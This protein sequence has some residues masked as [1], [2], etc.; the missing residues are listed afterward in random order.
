MKRERQIEVSESMNKVL[1]SVKAKET[2]IRQGMVRAL[3]KTALWVRTRLTK[4]LSQK[5]EI[6]QKLLRQRIWLRRATRNYMNARIRV[7]LYGIKA[8]KLG[9]MRQTAKGTFAGRKFFEG[10]FIATMPTG[11]TEV[12]KRKYSS[13]LPIRKEKVEIEQDVIETARKLENYNTE[14]VFERYFRHELN[15][16]LKKL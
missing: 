8:S 5:V 14:R 15:Y 10:A 12:F 7:G 3:N 13:S 11:P 16:I 1:Q 4:E 9:K 2:Q 6:K